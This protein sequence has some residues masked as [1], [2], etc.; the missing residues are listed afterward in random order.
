MLL[1]PVLTIPTVSPTR[2]ACDVESFRH[3]HVRRCRCYRRPYNSIGRPGPGRRASVSMENGR[4]IRK[5]ARG[6]ASGDRRVSGE[7]RSSSL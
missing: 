4:R 2:Y 1:N 5:P 3:G 6:S 7:T